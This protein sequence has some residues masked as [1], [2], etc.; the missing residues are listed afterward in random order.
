MHTH[1]HRPVVA[2]KTSKQTKKKTS[3]ILFWFA[4]T[5]P[6]GNFRSIFYEI[7]KM[8]IFL[9]SF[10]LLCVSLLFLYIFFFFLVHSRVKCNQRTDVD[11][12]R[13]NVRPK[14]SEMCMLHCQVEGGYN[15]GVGEEEGGENVKCSK[16][17]NL[18]FRLCTEAT[19]QKKIQS[20]IP[21]FFAESCLCNF[22][23]LICLKI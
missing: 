20:E 13:V 9:A 8:H 2:V 22:P 12:R 14:T 4:L 21:H 19:R 1:A 5:S 16:E 7:G 23:V 6:T 15:G 3:L 17:C 18:F 10:S 11:F